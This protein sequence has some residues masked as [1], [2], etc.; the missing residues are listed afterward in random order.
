MTLSGQIAWRTSG[1]YTT[2][3]KRWRD[4]AGELQVGL[5]LCVVARF[6]YEVF[7]QDSGGKRSVGT[8][9]VA[10]PFSRATFE[11]DDLDLEDGAVI[12]TSVTGL[13]PAALSTTSSLPTVTVDTS[14]P[15]GVEVYVVDTSRD[16]VP[17][18]VTA[19][20]FQPKARTFGCEDPQSG[21]Q[22]VEVSLVDASCTAFSG[23]TVLWSTVHLWGGDQETAVDGWDSIMV[24]GTR[25]RFEATCVAGS[26]A[27]TTASA[28]FWFE[29]QGP[30][31]G[32]ATVGLPSGPV[33]EFQC[34]PDTAYVWWNGFDGRNAGI[35]SYVAC[36]AASMAARLFTSWHGVCQV[37]CH[38]R[39]RE[40][41]R[42][43][44]VA[45]IQQHGHSHDVRRVRHA[46]GPQPRVQVHGAAMEA[47][48][49]CLACAH[50]CSPPYAQVQAFSHASGIGSP[51]IESPT[52]L[53]DL[54]DPEVGALDVK[55]TNASRRVDLTWYVERCLFALKPQRRVVNTSWHWLTGTARGRT[56]SL[57]SQN[58]GGGWAQPIPQ[59]TSTARSS[60]SHRSS[61]PPPW[62]PL[63]S[64]PTELS[65]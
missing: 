39:C 44:A 11:S 28:E 53:V 40:R 24:S 26:T 5:T 38:A 56:R 9:E 55:L 34:D 18:T 15:Y 65:T 1:A 59:Q 29:T 52:F 60:S 31:F 51:V 10:H 37:H 46:S 57:K 19:V 3:A 35:E 21:V 64:S 14:P 63:R 32:T 17:G 49:R 48:R 36:G 54:T 6:S 7:V 8:G 22:R 43:G 45:V 2:A 61:Q 33:V 30:Q 50:L 13:S 4:L 23:C 12:S 25:Y 62:C 20:A 16:M 58:I 27:T 41:R 47:L 42:G